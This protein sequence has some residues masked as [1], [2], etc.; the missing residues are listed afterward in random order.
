MFRRV[1]SAFSRLRLLMST[2]SAI[3]PA[4]RGVLDEID[5]QLG[6][7]ELGHGLLDKLV[8]DGLLVWFS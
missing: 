1:R 6:A 3:L 8:V 2:C 7:E 5:L 4:S